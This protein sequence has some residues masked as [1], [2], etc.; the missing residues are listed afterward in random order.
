MRSLP[1]SCIS[2]FSMDWSFCLNGLIAGMRTARSTFFLLVRYICPRKQ[3]KKS[4]T[5]SLAQWYPATQQYET[6]RDCWNIAVNLADMVTVVPETGS[7]VLTSLFEEKNRLQAVQSVVPTQESG[8][9]GFQAKK[10]QSREKNGASGP[11]MQV[12]CRLT[13]MRYIRTMILHSDN[14]IRCHRY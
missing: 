11:A 10:K 8:H 2:W 14:G 5:F 4:L 3:G 7:F 1:F 6:P 13:T 12:Q 9:F